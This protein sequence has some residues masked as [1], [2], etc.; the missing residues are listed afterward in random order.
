MENSLLKRRGKQAQGLQVTV[1]PTQSS[2]EVH[3]PRSMRES[4]RASPYARSSPYERRKQLPPLPLQPAPSLPTPGTQ[5][6]AHIDGLALA[7]I[8]GPISA[9]TR[10]ATKAAQRPDMTGELDAYLQVH[11][12]TTERTPPT[13]SAA[14]PTF[15]PPSFAP[16]S[17]V[18]QPPPPNARRTAKPAKLAAVRVGREKHRLRPETMEVE[19]ED[20][21]DQAHMCQMIKMLRQYDAPTPAPPPPPAATSDLNHDELAELR[22]RMSTALGEAGG[23]GQLDAHAVW[24]STQQ[25]TTVARVR[26]TSL[27]RHQLPRFLG[28]L[29]RAGTTGAAL[30]W[31]KQQPGDEWTLDRLWAATG[32]SAPCLTEDVLLTGL[33][34]AFS[35]S[36]A[37]RLRWNWQVLL[38]LPA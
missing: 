2:V 8:G 1:A 29:A 10:R 4:R 11:G 37:A 15:A 17:L 21:A 5:L 7:P 18:P 30:G 14:A 35:N 32:G 38:P 31:G 33:G 26:A 24:L 34:G 20:S 12:F 6:C 22:T 16:P 3:R 13:V 25:A 23:R 28:L 27:A 36:L 9:R 19:Q